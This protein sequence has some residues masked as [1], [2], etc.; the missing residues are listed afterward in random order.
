R[1]HQRAEKSWDLD[2]LR[3]FV[4]PLPMDSRIVDLGCSGLDTLVMLWLLGFRNLIG[5]DLH[6]SWN[7]RTYALKTA[8][9]RRLRRLPFHVRRRDLLQT[10]LD[11]RSIDLTVCVSTIE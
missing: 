2:Q 3:Q 5:M 8:L 11:D 4:D 10:G 7:E 9:R 6:L 1:P